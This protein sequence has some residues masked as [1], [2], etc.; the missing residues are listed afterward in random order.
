MRKILLP[1][2]V[3]LFF[4]IAG[5]VAIA[6][7]PTIAASPCD[8]NY[9]SS[10]KDRAWLEAQREITQNQNLIYKPDSVLEYTCFDKLANVFVQQAPNMF[11]QTTRWGTILPPNHMRDSLRAL[12]DAALSNY[13]SSNFSHTFMGGRS[14]S[15]NYT[16]STV[17]SG[18]YNCDRMRVIWQEAKCMDFIS[19]TKHDGFYTFTQYD[20]GPDHRFLPSVCSKPSPGYATHANF[21]YGTTTP[22]TED[23]VV[24]YANLLD[25]ANCANAA[26]I[27]PIET[28]IVVRRTTQAPNVYN[29]KVCVPP[30]CRYT[31]TSTTAGTCQSP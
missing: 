28:G 3:F 6:G 12:L 30:G 16:P 27:K 11:S 5:S 29:E 22:W 21:A 2:L 26:I 8:P 1:I 14:A 23:N 24:S 18:S 25:P 20:T 4:A 15:S 19:N 9:Y 10:L 17:T 13:I 31:P 7:T